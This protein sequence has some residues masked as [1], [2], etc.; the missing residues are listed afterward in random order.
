MFQQIRLILYTEQESTVEDAPEHS[1]GG[2]E[3]SHCFSTYEMS[4]L[5]LHLA[6][7]K[8]ELYYPANLGAT[9][10]N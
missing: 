10:K 2:T 6:L 9:S 5:L 7:L 4:I 3:P 1:H 8:S